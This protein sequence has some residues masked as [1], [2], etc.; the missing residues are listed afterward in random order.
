MSYSIDMPRP[1]KVRSSARSA[2]R[3]LIAVL[4]V[5]G[6]PLCA[7][8]PSSKNIL[9]DEHFLGDDTLY[10][11]PKLGAFRRELAGNM[12]ELF[13]PGS[14]APLLVGGL[15]VGASV[16]PEQNA[17]TFFLGTKRFDSFAAPG[18]QMGQDYIL[19]PAFAAMLLGSRAT[20]NRKFRNFAYSLAQGYVMNNLIVRP[21]KSLVGRQ[22]PSA[23]NHQSFPSLHA[24]H[25]FMWAG[26]VARHYG[27]KAGIPAFL[28][29]SYVGWS[30]LAHNKHHLTDV[31]A[32]AAL[33]YLVARTVNRRMQGPKSSGINWGIAPIGRGFAG[34]VSFTF[35]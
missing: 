25:S 34:S 32:G 33:G 23:E 35:N 28:A 30:R 12:R 15:T 6:G 20:D 3:T 27:K 4:V 13:S 19:G 8:T 22:R 17:E 1:P 31:V 14:L 5:V 24:A 7:Q 29:A 9:S 2:M 21:A 18:H 16:I 11:D 10:R 26:V